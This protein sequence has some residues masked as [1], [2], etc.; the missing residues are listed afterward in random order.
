M[1]NS[2]SRKEL[3]RSIL[4]VFGKGVSDHWITD[5]D[6][7]YSKYF[8]RKTLKRLSKKSLT[9][10]TVKDVEEF[11]DVFGPLISEMK[12]S[13]KNLVNY[14]ETRIGPQRSDRNFVKRYFAKGSGRENVESAM[15]QTLCSMLPFVTAEGKVICIFYIT[16]ANFKESKSAKV[17]F[18]IATDITWKRNSGFR[19]FLCFSDSGFLNAKLFKVILEKFEAV[20]HADNPGLNCLLL[21]DNGSS[22]MN[23]SAILKMAVKGVRMCFFAPLTTHF[24]Q[25]LDD[26]IF[27]RLKP[28]VH[29]LLEEKIFHRLLF[30]LP[31]KLWTVGEAQ[32]AAIG[33]FTEKTI[34]KAFHDTGIWPFDG[35][36]LIGLASQELEKNGGTEYPNLQRDTLSLTRAV[37]REAK[38]DETFR[39]LRRKTGKVTVRKERIYTGEQL[40]E[41]ANEQE[42]SKA[43]KLEISARKK[44]ESADKK[45]QREQSKKD[46]LVNRQR[47]RKEMETKK[48]KLKAKRKANRC[49][50]CNGIYR[51]G[52]GWMGCDKCDDFWV[53]PTCYKKN[54][55]FL[56]NHENYCSSNEHYDT[57]END[58]E[59]EMGTENEDDNVDMDEEM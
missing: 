45:Q 42:K 55:S 51:G 8:A 7:R 41:Q 29:F 24:S 11:V 38:K 59:L 36:K 43:E 18:E 28:L 14:D 44:K 25:P 2:L 50:H 49:K 21:G 56:S 1:K 27:A 34:K 15:D 53:C 19:E 32:D 31:T 40:L 46:K 20:W 12:L 47:K 10:F 4:D 23:P 22:H 57:D 13:A 17:S 5:F 26:T 37:I 54:P 30:D 33:T 58:Q 3:K 48:E 35:K 52:K 6:N 16:K 9:P 39:Q